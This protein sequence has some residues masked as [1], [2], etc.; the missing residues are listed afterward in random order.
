MCFCSDNLENAWH[1]LFGC[2]QAKAMWE[3]AGLWTMIE[4]HF[5]YVEC[6]NEL[7]F[8]ILG[9]ATMEIKPFL[10]WLYGAFGGARMI[11][12]GKGL[13]HNLKYLSPW[14]CNISMTGLMRGLRRTNTITIH[15]C[16]ISIDAAL[17]QQQN[18]HGMGACIWDHHG[19]FITC[20]NDKVYIQLE[21]RVLG[22]LKLKV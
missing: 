8:W 9:S 20:S 5:Q 13:K 7:I 2:A 12:F 3:V 16:N 14:P 17:F 21:S 11:S 19:R 15:N 10:L 22:K 6:T 18:C 1:L 4:P